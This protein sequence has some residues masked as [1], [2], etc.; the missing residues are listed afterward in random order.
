MTRINGATLPVLEIPWP[1]CGHCGQ[2]VQLEDGAAWCYSCLVM[3]PRY[4]DGE[5]SEFDMNQV[6]SLQMCRKPP[7]QRIREYDHAGRHV[8]VTYRLCILP[9]SHTSPCLHPEDYESEPVDAA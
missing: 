1:K 8:T 4:G 6:D 9:R 2:D 5:V 3:W 7:K